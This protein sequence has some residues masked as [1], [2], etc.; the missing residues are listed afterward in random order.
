LFTSL[1]DATAARQ[2]FIEHTG[3]NE[4]VKEFGKIG[5]VEIITAFLGNTPS[6][7]AII[8]YYQNQ[9]I[10]HHGASLS[11]GIPTSPLLQWEAIKRAKERHLSQY[12]FWGVAPPDKP[13]HPWNGLSRFKRGFGGIEKEFSASYDIPITF[14]YH[15]MHLLEIW[16]KYKKGY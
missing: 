7:S 2:G 13:K 12:N 14:K 10:Y 4:E 9:G 3:I 15:G 11:E 6:A 5:D 8:L 1:Y 16:R